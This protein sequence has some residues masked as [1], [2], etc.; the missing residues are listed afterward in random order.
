MKSAIWLTAL[1]LGTACSLPPVDPFAGA[2]SAIK[3]RQ[4]LA[5]LK[6]LESVPVDDPRYQDARVVAS[7]VERRIRRSHESVLEAL[8][9]R[10]EWRDT[11]A[12]HA[13]HRAKQEWPGQ[14]DLDQWISATR[15]RLELFGYGTPRAFAAAEQGLEPANSSEVEAGDV[16]SSLGSPEYSPGD[17]AAL[18]FIDRDAEEDRSIEVPEPESPEGVG[19]QE[20]LSP[21][22]STNPADL[23]EQVPVQEALASPDSQVT[24][25]DLPPEATAKVDYEPRA[26]ILR[27]E[28][29]PSEIMNGGAPEVLGNATNSESNVVVAPVAEA[30]QEVQVGSAA[31]AIV[32]T[33]RPPLSDDPVALGLVSVE[34]RIGLGEFDL[35]VLDLVELL[36]RFPKDRRIHRRVIGLLYQRALMHYGRGKIAAA[37]ADWQFLLEMDPGNRAVEK[38]VTRAVTESEQANK[39]R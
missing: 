38:M 24:G 25:V 36:Q 14:P 28:S 26:S 1:L 35:A 4:L 5:A 30:S 32:E 18:R 20:G 8:Q 34:A 39:L 12:L 15:K 29:E 9:L 6:H 19:V 3:S 17:L 31:P 10:S 13:L 16:S 37:V 2:E 7:Q 23:I 33:A 27:D 21:L 11:E 22:A